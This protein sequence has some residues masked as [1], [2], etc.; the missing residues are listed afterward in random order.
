MAL[1]GMGGLVSEPGENKNK[2][3]DIFKRLCPLTN[4]HRH[5]GASLDS[6]RLPPSCKKPVPMHNLLKSSR[7]QDTQVWAQ[8]SKPTVFSPPGQVPNRGRH[9]GNLGIVPGTPQFARSHCCNACLPPAKKTAVQEN[10]SSKN[11]AAPV[12]ENLPKAHRLGL[13]G[14]QPVEGLAATGRS[15]LF[16][17]TSSGT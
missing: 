10:G 16:L 12:T 6:L 3:K 17:Q 5:F 15:M 13:Y 2:D 1:L 11:P 4:P 9:T 8:E 7:G 14:Q